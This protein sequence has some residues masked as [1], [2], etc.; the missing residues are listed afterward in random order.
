MGHLEVECLGIRSNWL[1]EEFE[2][3]IGIGLLCVSEPPIEGGGGEDEG[4]AGEGEPA[5]SSGGGEALM[6]LSG[7]LGMEEIM[8]LKRWVG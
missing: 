4:G 3:E 6:G 1:L 8:P 2:A 5:I 7:V